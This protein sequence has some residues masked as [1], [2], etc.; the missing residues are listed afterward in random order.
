ME[1]RA[2]GYDCFGGDPAAVWMTYVSLCCD[3]GNQTRQMGNPLSA[4]SAASLKNS[5][6]VLI[7]L[8]GMAVRRSIALNGD[9]V[10]STGCKARRHRF[11]WPTPPLAGWR[12]PSHPEQYCLKRWSG[13]SVRAFD[14]SLLSAGFSFHCISSSPV[15]G[16]RARCPL[17]TTHRVGPALRRPLVSVCVTLPSVSPSCLARGCGS[18]RPV[19]DGKSRAHRA[20]SLQELGCLTTPLASIPRGCKTEPS[21]SAFFHKAQ[22]SRYQRRRPRPALLK[23]AAIIMIRNKPNFG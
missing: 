16:L 13:A 14:S 4:K 19:R 17:S 3:P 9:A 5:R 2:C 20:M 12:N 6:K 18:R 11:V 7:R 15:R 8:S 1:I 21:R 10:G 23:A 22:P